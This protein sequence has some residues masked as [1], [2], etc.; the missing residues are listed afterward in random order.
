LHAAVFAVDADRLFREGGRTPTGSELADLDAA[1][2]ESSAA[3]DRSLE[4][5][6]GQVN[7]PNLPDGV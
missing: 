4:E 5:L 1:I 6:R 3:V 7:S 2:R